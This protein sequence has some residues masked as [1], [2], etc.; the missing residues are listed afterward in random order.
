MAQ[1]VVC[2]GAV[3]RRGHEVLLVRQAAGHS[4][5]GQ[6][7]IPWGRLESGES[8]VAAA[9]RETREEGGVDT[10][11]V[12]FLGVQ[13]LPPPWAGWLALIYMCNHAGGTPHGDGIETDAARYFSA[14]SLAALDE[15]LEPWSRWLVERF[16]AGRGTAIAADTSNPFQPNA[17]FLL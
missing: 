10:S 2:V 13:E 16:M 6:W 1:T 7:T 14:A 12:G 3:V 9:I 4:L 17:G 15:P 8:P 5:Q 11:L